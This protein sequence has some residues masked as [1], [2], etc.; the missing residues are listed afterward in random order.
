[1]IRGLDLRETN[2]ILVELF[3]TNLVLE[4]EVWVQV[5]HGVLGHGWL[6]WAEAP[7]SHKVLE[8]QVLE[9][10]ILDL[11]KL[12][13]WSVH[14]ELLKICIVWMDASGLWI[15]IVEDFKDIGDVLEDS[16]QAVRIKQEGRQDEGAEN[17]RRSCMPHGSGRGHRR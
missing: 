1:M 17:L 16:L 15:L 5:D 8:R 13:S 12:G 14:F 6:G 2:M 11:L 4:S 7:L 10:R 3:K 9:V